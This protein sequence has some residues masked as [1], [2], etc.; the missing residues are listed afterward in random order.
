MLDLDCK[1][2]RPKFVK[3]HRNRQWH[4]LAKDANT[5]DVDGDDD[6]SG[7]EEEREKKEKLLNNDLHILTFMKRGMIKG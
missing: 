6:T 1:V 7:E 4:Y 2:K 3:I 5:D